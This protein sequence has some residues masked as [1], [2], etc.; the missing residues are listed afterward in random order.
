MGISSVRKK[1]DV[2]SF[3]WENAIVQKRY[4]MVQPMKSAQ[5]S[6]AF[7]IHGYDILT[8]I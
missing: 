5:A 8:E 4:F 6:S 1:F 2:V 3:W 7:F